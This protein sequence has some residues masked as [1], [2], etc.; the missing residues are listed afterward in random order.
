MTQSAESLTT[1]WFGAPDESPLSRV[2]GKA[3]PPIGE[4][5]T[6]CSSP[7]TVNDA[8]I[9]GMSMRKTGGF[10]AR[11]GRFILHAQCITGHAPAM[12]N[13]PVQRAENRVEDAE[14]MAP[15]QTRYRDWERE[16]PGE[17][18][19][20]PPADLE[21]LKRRRDDLQRDYDE[22]S[23]EPDSGAHKDVMAKIRRLGVLSSALS[24][25]E[26]EIRA[27]EG[28]YTWFGGTLDAIVDESVTARI[29]TKAVVLA[30][31]EMLPGF[32]ERYSRRFDEMVNRDFDPLY[33]LATNAPWATQDAHA[34]WAR[35]VGTPVYGLFTDADTAEQLSDS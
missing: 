6:A 15:V 24:E 29:R 9:V 13:T 27:G 10:K 8:G 30:L 4:R 5:C 7:I 33:H 21:E 23:A 28:A 25:L 32:A 35:D 22:L 19:P 20:F 3:E 12:T 18:P 34:A 26:S 16:H 17:R 14:P 31:D 2:L 1:Q 11:Q